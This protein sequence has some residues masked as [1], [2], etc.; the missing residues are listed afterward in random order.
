MVGPSHT[1][2]PSRIGS[3]FPGISRSASIRSIGRLLLAALAQRAARVGAGLPHP[4]RELSGRQVSW[5]SSGLPSSAHG[6]GPDCHV[7]LGS[8]PDGYA[9]TVPLEGFR[10]IH[11]SGE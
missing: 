11:H 1:T 6:S 9:D 8:K 3:P 7:V 2:T 10:G 4:R 5:H